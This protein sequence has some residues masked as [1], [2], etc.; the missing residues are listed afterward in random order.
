[1]SKLTPAIILVL[2][3]AASCRPDKEAYRKDFVKGCVTRFAKDSTVASTEGR[4]LVETYCNCM[5]DKLS[6]Q[7]DADEWRTF[8]KSNDT[9]MTRFREALQPC[10]DSFQKKLATLK[11]ASAE[12]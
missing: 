5:G 4:I 7:M 3:A 12:D 1:M 2:L 10:K 6:A 8:N 11:P 9:A